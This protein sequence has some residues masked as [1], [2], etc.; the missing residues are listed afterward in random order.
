[1]SES[2]VRPLCS[3]VLLWM[4]SFSSLTLCHV[5]VSAGHQR[6]Y[7]GELPGV[8]KSSPFLHC[9]VFLWSASSMQVQPTTH[10]AIR[11][12]AHVCRL[13]MRTTINDFRQTD[14]S[15]VLYPAQQL[16]L[17]NWTSVM[18]NHLIWG[19][20]MCCVRVRQGAGCVGTRESQTERHGELPS[21]GN[22]GGAGGC[23]A[24]A[25]ETATSLLQ[26][27][28]DHLPQPRYMASKNYLMNQ[29]CLTHRWWKVP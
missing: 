5:I 15:L 11:S 2:C 26:R 14:F 12:C 13:V 18:R 4:C 9:A 27:C 28:A 23:A 20:Y 22:F 25:G 1:M 10:T 17:N 8:H 7:P 29:V 6:V 24:P 3:N 21:S 16:N 19:L